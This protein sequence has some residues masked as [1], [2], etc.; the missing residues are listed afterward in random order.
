LG[1]LGITMIESPGG[2]IMSEATEAVVEQLQHENERLRMLI[3][4]LQ[5]DRRLTI[6]SLDEIGD[7]L[8]DHWWVINLVGIIMGLLLVS[9]DILR[10]GK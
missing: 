2:T 6:P 5:Y 8:A 3:V 7:W 1:A 10:R 9:I 4:K